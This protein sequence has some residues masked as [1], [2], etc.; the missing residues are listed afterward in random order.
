MGV[1]SKADAAVR[2][3]QSMH[4]EVKALKQSVS[5]D[6]PER[7]KYLEQVGLL[8]Y[9]L[10]AQT[11]SAGSK[12][13]PLWLDARDSRL[14]ILQ[15]AGAEPISGSFDGNTII[16]MRI[17]TLYKD[18][19]HI[20]KIYKMIGDIALVQRLF[21]LVEIDGAHYAVMQDLNGFNNLA[22]MTATEDF[23]G[24]SNMTKLRFLYELAATLSALHSSHLLVKSLSDQ[25]VFIDASHGEP[26]PLLS[27]LPAARDVCISLSKPSH[28]DC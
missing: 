7:K 15:R 5:N 1:D 13:S 23:S 25:T 18:L 9:E 27:N 22:E 26:R 10:S 11:R 12:A 28:R 20:T 6:L 19:D 2:D 17:G 24:F 8:T 21:G 16:F 4:H 14:R 3:L